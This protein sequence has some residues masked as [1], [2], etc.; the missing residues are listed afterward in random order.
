MGLNYR[1]AQFLISCSAPGSPLVNKVDF[2]KTLMLGR[3]GFTPSKRDCIKLLKEIFK[4]EFTEKHSKDFFDALSKATSTRYPGNT[5]AE[6]FFKLIGTSIESLD[7]SDYED[8]TIV[9]DL[10]KP[11]P[12][13][14][15]NKYSCVIDGGTLEHVYDYPTAFKNAMDLVAVGGHIILLTPG[16]NF[17]GHGF[18]QLSPELFY[19]ILR[20]ENGFA[21][22]QI[23]CNNGDK[24]Y[25]I[26]DPRVIHRRTEFSPSW[27]NML[28]YV[29]SRKIDEVPD[30]VRAY[31]SDYENAWSQGDGSNNL[32]E[33][34]SALKDTVHF[35]NNRLSECGIGGIIKNI[36]YKFRNKK[37]FKNSTTRIRL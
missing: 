32:N 8:A 19:S 3:Q 17:L 22:T 36:G 12:S 23:Y 31:Q 13:E 29:V 10:S 9:H 4:N 21:D 7:Y 18:Y 14:L 27:P 2:A 25:L 37:R 28:L 33:N 34:K 15:K 26:S 20:K 16:N 11:I 35:W 6:P 24:W 30:C 5:Y 1:T